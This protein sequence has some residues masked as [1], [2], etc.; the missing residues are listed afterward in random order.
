MKDALEA[1]ELAM[2]GNTNDNLEKK[3]DF[4]KKIGWNFQIESRR[5]EFEFKDS[6]GHLVGGEKKGLN[7]GGLGDLS[8]G[9]SEKD[10]NPSAAPAAAIFKQSRTILEMRPVWAKVGT[11]FNLFPPSLRPCPPSPSD[12]ARF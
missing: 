6:W 7:F 5:L 10:I 12:T 4:L 11:Y 2:G 9:R 8:G 1:S 3:R